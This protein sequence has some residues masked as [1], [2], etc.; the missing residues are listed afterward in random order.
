V[1][2]SG[3]DQTH[4]IVRNLKLLL[5]EIAIWLDVD[6]LENIGR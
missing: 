3:Q 6:N 5:P 1:W 2:G 4:T